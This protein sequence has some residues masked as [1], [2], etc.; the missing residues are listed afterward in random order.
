[1]PKTPPTSYVRAMGHVVFLARGSAPRG[2]LERVERPVLFEPDADRVEQ[3]GVERRAIRAHPGFDSRTSL[4]WTVA[5][6][7]IDVH[8]ADHVAG[9]GA[10]HGV[11]EPAALGE[12]PCVAF[13]IAQVVSQAHRVRP[14]GPG[15]PG[16]RLDVVAAGSP[17]GIVG[18]VVLWPERL[19]S[20]LLSRQ[21]AWHGELRGHEQAIEAG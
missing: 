12:V 10:Q 8:A 20:E 15:E 7:R 5:A 3:H 21:P 14:A 17:R 2:V 13:E 11:G 6:R 16:R 19:E 4:S 9:A 1:M 18:V